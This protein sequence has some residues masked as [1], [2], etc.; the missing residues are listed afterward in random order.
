MD[1]S[2]K[3]I[4]APANFLESEN[5]GNYYY[6]SCRM[7]WRISM[8]YLINGNQDAKKSE[9]KSIRGSINTDDKFNVADVVLL[10]NLVASCS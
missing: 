3:F 1:S 4:P 6:N 2:G 8:D 10:Q 7:P 9:N 5:D